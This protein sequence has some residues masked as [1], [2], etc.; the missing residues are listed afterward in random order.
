MERI[1]V[2]CGS[3]RGNEPVY[4]EATRELGLL[5]GEQGLGLVYGGASVGLMGVLADAVLE[6]GGEVIGVIP[7]FLQDKEVAHHGVTQLHVVDGMHARKA[8]MAD[9]ADAFIALPGGLGTLEELFEML[10]WGQLDMHTKPCGALNVD[11]YYTPLARFLDRMVDA[12][13]VRAEHRRLLTLDDSPEMLLRRL[14]DLYRRS[15]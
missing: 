11:D 5:L 12:G 9:L 15:L 4:A 14:E 6:A 7:R 2:Y 8:L 1:C 10:T 3:K 13:F